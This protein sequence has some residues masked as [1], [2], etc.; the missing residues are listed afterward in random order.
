MK[1]AESMEFLDEDMTTG[2]KPCIMINSVGY[3]LSMI[4]A[5]MP[6]Q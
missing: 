4:R 1:R 2:K 5:G 3:R 6:P